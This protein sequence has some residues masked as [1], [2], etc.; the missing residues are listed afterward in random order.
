MGGGTLFRINTDDSGFA[1]LLSFPDASDGGTAP[2]GVVVSGNTLYGTTAYGGRG[3]S[4][5]VF[6]LATDSSGFTRLHDFPACA[7]DPS[8][9]TETNG[10]GAYPQAALVL[11]GDTLYGTT[12]GGSGGGG[13][14][15]FAIGADGSGFAVLHPFMQSDGDSP[16]AELLLSGDML[17]GTTES[18]GSGGSGTI[19]VIN[20]DGSGF[21]GL[22]DFSLL[23]PTTRTNLDGANSYAERALLGN[24]VY[25]TTFNGGN[26]GEGTL[27]AF[28]LVAAPPALNVQCSGNAV[29]ISWPSA[30]TQFVL[31]Q[32]SDLGTADWATTG[33]SLSD[34][35]TTRSVTL[36]PPSGHLFF[37]L[38]KP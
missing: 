29:V 19:F 22:Y 34:D 24:T 8:S 15:V 20:P 11:S 23:D 36:T 33:F 1:R 5:T 27:F 18:G 9:G 14:T 12:S 13:G 28:S 30:A 37:R 26:A 2:N 16:S 31:Q 10:D 7:F 4:G 25:T 17:Y 32:N 38:A 21:T 3:H 6:K 35:G